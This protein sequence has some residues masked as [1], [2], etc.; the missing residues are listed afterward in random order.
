MKGQLKSQRMAQA[1]YQQVVRRKPT[2]KYRSFARRFPTL[3]HSCGLAQAVGFAASKGNKE[4]DIRDYVA[5]ITAVLQAG[6]YSDI[7]SLNEIARQA[8]SVSDY[9]RLTRDTLA[10]AV[11][12]K[13]YVEAM[14]SDQAALEVSRRA[15]PDR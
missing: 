9:L 6:G 3:V 4:E 8:A 14:E 13:R 2:E 12:L 11:W 1:A 5:D 15:E 10:A 7:G